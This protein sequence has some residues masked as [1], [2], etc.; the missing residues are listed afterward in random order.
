MWV[1]GLR[2]ASRRGNNIL[3]PKLARVAMAT[4]AVAGRQYRPIFTTRPAA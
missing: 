3:P 4:L 1:A 2:R